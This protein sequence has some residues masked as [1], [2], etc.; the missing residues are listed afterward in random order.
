[1]LFQYIY[2]FF[3]DLSFYSSWKKGVD[4][5]IWS[6]VLYIFIYG[7][8]NL[9]KGREILLKLSNNMNSK[10]YFSNL[11]DFIEVEEIE[12]LFRFNPP[13]TVGRDTQVKVISIWLKNIP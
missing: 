7:Y 11:S 4:F 2:P 5:S 9:S 10:R 12:N 1:M 6:L 8:H 3:R 13:F